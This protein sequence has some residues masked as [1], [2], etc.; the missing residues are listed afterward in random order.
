MEMHFTGIIPPAITCFT[1]QGEIDV[2]AQRAL[3]QFLSKHVQ[4]FFPCGTYGSGPLMTMA[5]R[6]QVAEIV[7]EEKGNT[8]AIIQVGAPSTREAIEL[9]KHAKAIG[10]DAIGAIPPYYYAYSQDQLIEYYR[11]IIN[12][13]DLPVFVYNNPELSRNPVNP[14]TLA[15]LA[16]HKL[17]GVKDSAFDLVNFYN[18]KLAVEKP[19][20]SFIVGTE[21]IAAAALD[22][23]ASGVIAGLAN[24][25]PEFMGDFFKTWQNGDAK[26]TAAKQLDVIQ[27]R[28]ILKLGPTMT[29]IYAT[30][31]MRG[32][33]PGYPRAPQ[34]EIP[35]ELYIRAEK[36]YHEMGLL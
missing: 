33:N 30:L 4:G 11:A 27:A 28:N 1:K 22:A 16:E 20:F 13:V 24:C 10:A 2:K 17:A 15:F 31:R 35:K 18:F 36:A 8:F 9:A 23:G 29:M 25:F 7:M 19:D 34:T 5:E 3:V 26:K 32:M 14:E 21:A 6:K 12:S